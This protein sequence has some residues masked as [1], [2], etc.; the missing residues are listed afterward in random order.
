VIV[1]RSGFGMT[2]DLTRAKLLMCSRCLKVKEL[3]S[4]ETGK[5][6]LI[7]LDVPTN[8]QNKRTKGESKAGQGSK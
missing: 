2:G 4:L 8:G 1:K 6:E 5:A 7:N 3:G